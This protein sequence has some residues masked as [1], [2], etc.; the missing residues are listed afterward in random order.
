M[1]FLC[2]FFFFMFEISSMST[3][4]YFVNMCLFF[5]DTLVE[6]A[7]GYCGTA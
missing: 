5:S 4:L 1:P 7:L 6:F 2:F 3:D